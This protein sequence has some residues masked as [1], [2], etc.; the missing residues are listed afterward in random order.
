MLWAHNQ[1]CLEDQGRGFER[2]STLSGSRWLPTLAEKVGC[3]Q[4]SLSANTMCP[5]R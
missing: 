2:R 5:F 1:P 4:L 3:C